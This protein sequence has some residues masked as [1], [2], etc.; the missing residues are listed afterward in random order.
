[1]TIMLEATIYYL[2]SL[3]EMANEIIDDLVLLEVSHSPLKSD[4]KRQKLMECVLTRNSKQYLG[5][6]RTS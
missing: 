3:I 1:M 4:L 5:K 6:A 2:Y